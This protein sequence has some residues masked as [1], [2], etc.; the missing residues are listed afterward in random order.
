LS[1]QRNSRTP[2]E[3]IVQLLR[4]PTQN[5]SNETVPVRMMQNVQG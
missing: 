1:N 3:Q 4:L 5:A 2:D